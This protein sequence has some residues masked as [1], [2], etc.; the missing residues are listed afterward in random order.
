MLNN[1]GQVFTTDLI[2]AAVV[3]LFIITFTTI[4]SN[5][6]SYRVTLMEGAEAREIAALNVLDSL[7]LSQGRP[8]NWELF[9]DLNRVSSIG[10]VSSI[11]DID[12]QKFEHMID[13]NALHYEA[14]RYILGAG[15]YE[16]NIS[17][18]DMQNRQVLG[19][20]GTRPLNTDKVTSV[21]RPVLYGGEDSLLR[22]ELFEE[23]AED[24]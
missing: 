13:M 6:I 19:E 5:E 10:L 24:E 8:A 9:S 20:F 23:A 22:V 16:M 12:E 1:R 18:L 11:G 17:I 4:Y 14:I 21:S 3:F 15:A 7:T 2:V